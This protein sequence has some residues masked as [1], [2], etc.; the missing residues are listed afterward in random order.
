MFDAIEDTPTEKLIAELESR[1]YTVSKPPRMRY[2]VWSDDDPE[3]RFE[4]LARNVDEAAWA[5]LDK[6]NWCV[7]ADPLPD[8]TP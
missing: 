4:V 2:M 1:G 7:G 6:L 3:D 5:A 8:D